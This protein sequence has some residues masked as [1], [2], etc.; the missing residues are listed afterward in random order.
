MTAGTLRIILVFI[1]L[2]G[3]LDTAPAQAPAHPDLY[4]YKPPSVLANGT[5]V[6]GE[7]TFAVSEITT[8]IP[9]VQEMRGVILIVY[10]STICPTEDHCDFSLIDQALDYWK[11][12]GKKIVLGVATIGYPRKIL[13]G[14]TEVLVGATPDWVMKRTGTYSR[15]S[16]TFGEIGGN[17]LNSKAMTNFPKF[18]QPE[19]LT[20]IGKLIHQLAQRYDGNPTI[21]QLRMSLGLTT[22]E[23][24]PVGWFGQTPP[25][26]SEMGWIDICSKI[27]GMFE[28]EFH[29]TRLEFDISRMA[30][31]YVFLKDPA[32]KPAVDNLINSLE[33]HGVFLAYDTLRS[34]S[35]RD[36]K[37]NNYANALVQRFAR[38]PAH[39]GGGLELNGGLWFHDDIPDLAKVV[40]RI[41]PNRLVMFGPEAASLNYIR[42]GLNPQNKVVVDWFGPK[43]LQKEIDNMTQFMKLIGYD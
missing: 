35:D 38:N 11:R 25:G 20:E 40:N 43:V 16:V 24:P 39:N 8:D 12:Q 13:R 14:G 23:G 19:Y 10:W 27:V 34:D 30:S 2:L 32:Y 28:R 4:F 33:Q 42:R 36:Y 22:E 31:G 9:A 5:R 26:Y 41:R 21:A 17:G 3:A 18:W 6:A 29:K 7:G 37:K 1:L 15:E